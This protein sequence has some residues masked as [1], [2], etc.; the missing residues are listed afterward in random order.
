MITKRKMFAYPREENP[1]AHNVNYKS[2]TIDI[3]LSI[4]SEDPIEE[5][6]LFAVLTVYTLLARKLPLASK[7]FFGIIPNIL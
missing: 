2:T 6:I 7:L 1:V 4:L 3:A 5:I